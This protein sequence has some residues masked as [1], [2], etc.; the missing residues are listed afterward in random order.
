MGRGRRSRLF[1]DLQRVATRCDAA[2]S[3]LPFAACAFLEVG[4]RLECGTTLPYISPVAMAASWPNRLKIFGAD[5]GF[6]AVVLQY[7]LLRRPLSPIAPE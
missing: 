3:N 7:C 2:S 4:E 1:A 6:A 5:S